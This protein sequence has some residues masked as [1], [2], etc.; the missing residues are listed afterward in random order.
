MIIPRGL[1]YRMPNILPF[2]GV[3]DIYIFGYLFEL[4]YIIEAS[5]YL[6][7]DYAIAEEKKDLQ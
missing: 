2:I 5:L 6:G 4:Q 3:Y 1:E 7:K